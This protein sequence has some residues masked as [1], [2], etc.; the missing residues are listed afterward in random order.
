MMHIS[1]SRFINWTR[2]PMYFP[3]ELK[4][5]PTGEVDIEAERE[6]REEMLMELAEGMASDKSDE[7]DEEESTQ[8]AEY[9]S[10][11]ITGLSPNTSYYF[12]RQSLNG[13]DIIDEEN[14]TFETL[15]SPE[16]IDNISN[17]SA[18]TKV[19]SNGSVFIKQGDKTYTL[20]GQEVK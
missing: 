6:R 1:K 3:M 4:H 10:F 18:P 11:T 8:F 2:C 12:V 14:G 17:A 19:I 16:A 5:N 20:H 9:Y 15:S 13:T 7:E